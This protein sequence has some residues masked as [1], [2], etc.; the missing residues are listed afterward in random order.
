VPF[1]QNVFTTAATRISNAMSDASPDLIRDNLDTDPLNPSRDA[2]TDFDLLLKISVTYD[3]DSCRDCPDAVD[4]PAV[5]LGGT[6]RLSPT[7]NRA[8]DWTPPPSR[9]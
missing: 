6:R 2:F 3:A 5:A 4:R 9:R 7:R 8:R 1:H